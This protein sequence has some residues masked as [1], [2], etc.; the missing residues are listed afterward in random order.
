[1]YWRQV[2]FILF[3]H[4]NSLSL[5]I[6]FVHCTQLSEYKTHETTILIC[7]LCVVNI[8]HRKWNLVWHPS[9]FIFLAQCIQMLQVLI[10][11]FHSSFKH[12]V[13]IFKRNGCA[14]VRTRL[15][16]LVLAKYRQANKQ[17]HGVLQ[18]EVKCFIWEKKQAM[19]SLQGMADESF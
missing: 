11:F 6:I 5:L 9:F 4:H 7:L 3:L 1:M 17:D 16:K 13:T 10:L 12:D 15:P 8:F 19:I 2:A 14:E 18:A